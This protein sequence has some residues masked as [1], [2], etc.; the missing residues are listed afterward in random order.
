[1]SPPAARS[2]RHPRAFATSPRRRRRVLLS[3]AGEETEGEGDDPPALSVISAAG[4]SP[5]PVADSTSS[6]RVAPSVQKQLPAERVQ[7]VS[8]RISPPPPCCFLRQLVVGSAAFCAQSPEATKGDTY[9]C[10]ARLG[11]AFPRS[12][13]DALAETEEEAAVARAVAMSRHR[14]R[15]ALPSWHP[16]VLGGGRA[17]GRAAAQR[18]SSSSGRRRGRYTGVSSGGES[19]DEGSGPRSVSLV[20]E[21]E[22]SPAEFAGRVEWVVA[23]QAALVQFDQSAEG[24]AVGGW[25][26]VPGLLSSSS[27][28]TSSPTPTPPSVSS[29]SPSPPSQ[30]SSSSSPSP[31]LP[32]SSSSSQSSSSSSASQSSSSSSASSSSSSSSASSSTPSQPSSFP[33]PSPFFSALHHVF[34]PPL[35][36][37]V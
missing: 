4:I 34:I 10:L 21:D 16:L 9:E 29:S 25:E 12:S 28:N 32:A 6:A 1:M 14:W 20:T 15:G 31:Q 8:R 17:A 37:Y 3:S 11:S 23:T 13:Y 18:I 27:L 19:G 26:V 36:F 2:E 22:L 5:G 7:S 30:S 24:M 35:A 33:L